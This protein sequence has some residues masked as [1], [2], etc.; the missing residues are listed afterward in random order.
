MIIHLWSWYGAL[1]AVAIPLS[2]TPYQPGVWHHSLYK[3]V[4]PVATGSH[5]YKVLYM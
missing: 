4:G 3:V 2:G 1:V 5:L